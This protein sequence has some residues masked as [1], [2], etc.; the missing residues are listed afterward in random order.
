MI[1]AKTT[2]T[3]F[4]ETGA[5]YGGIADIH[6]CACVVNEVFSRTMT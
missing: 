6:E 2:K 4:S 5:N 3:V 1:L